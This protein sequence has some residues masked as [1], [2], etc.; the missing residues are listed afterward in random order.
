VQTLLFY[1]PFQIFRRK[2]S[3]AHHRIVFI[4]RFHQNCLL[5][6]ILNSVHSF[7]LVFGLRV[8]WQQ[9]WCCNSLFL[10]Y[11]EAITLQHRGSQPLCRANSTCHNALELAEFDSLYVMCKKALS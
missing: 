9:Q 11:V 10:R 7:I 3:H 4:P 6:F 2:F 5:T 1:D 8:I